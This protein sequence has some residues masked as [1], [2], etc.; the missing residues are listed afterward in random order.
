MPQQ[1]TDVEILKE[2]IN[3]VIERAKHHAGDVNEIVLALAGAI[4]WKKDIEPIEVFTRKGEMKNV[5]WVKINRKKYA[6]SYNH[7]S[8]MVELREGT[9][10]G[11]LLHSFSNSTQIT[12][13]RTIFESL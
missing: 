11:A 7:E 2:Y 10:Q 12:N 8:G 9:T 1:I 3:G 6:F 5:L 13:V 4:V